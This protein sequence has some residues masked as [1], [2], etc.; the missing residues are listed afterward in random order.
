[1]GFD[2]IEFGLWPIIYI[3][4]LGAA[5]FDAFLET[6]QYVGSRKTYNMLVLIYTYVGMEGGKY[7]HEDITNKSS[8][9]MLV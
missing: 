9:F 7:L 6:Q 5:R 8:V 4:V 2:L 3:E 1:M